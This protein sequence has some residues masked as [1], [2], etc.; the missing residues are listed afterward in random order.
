VFHFL[1]EAESDVEHALF[2][3]RLFGSPRA[4]WENFY[5][6]ECLGSRLLQIHFDAEREG[7]CTPQRASL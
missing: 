1:S 4:G 5:A 6:V 3:V 7:C 2:I